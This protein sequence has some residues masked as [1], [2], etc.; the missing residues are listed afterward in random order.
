MGCPEHDHP[1]FM[2]DRQVLA[3]CTSMIL[4]GS[5]TTAISLSAVFYY[6]VQNPRVYKKLMAE[7]DGAAKEGLIADKEN[8]KVSWNESQKLKYLDAVIQE[9]FR[10]S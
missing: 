2:T 7:L 10:M 6:L 5:E 8:N 4:A 1:E 9:S 3:S